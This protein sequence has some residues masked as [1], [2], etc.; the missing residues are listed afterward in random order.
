[1]TEFELDQTTNHERG[2][3]ITFAPNRIDVLILIALVVCLTALVTSIV[4][5]ANELQQRDARLDQPFLYGLIALA[6]AVGSV[7]TFRRLSVRFSIAI[8]MVLL[9]GLSIHHFGAGFV[10]STFPISQPFFLPD[11]PSDFPWFESV[12]LFLAAVLGSICAGWL[13]LAILNITWQRLGFV[14]KLWAWLVA[15]RL[16]FMIGA[17]GLLFVLQTIQ[18]IWFKEGFGQSLTPN[19]SFRAAT[20]F[21]LD[22]LLGIGVTALILAACLFATTKIALSKWDYVLRFVLM[23]LIGGLV[24][25]PAFVNSQAPYNSDTQQLHL[26]AS[27]LTVAVVYFFGLL[28]IVNPEPADAE[29]RA[30]ESRIPS[31][32]SLMLAIPLCGAIA[33]GLYVYDPIWLVNPAGSRRA[34]NVGSLEMASLSR[35]LSRES[36][37]RIG[38]MPA[39]SSASWNVA[40]HDK[41]DKDIFGHPFDFSLSQ[42]IIV[43]NIQPFVD[44]SLLIDPTPVNSKRPPI[45]LSLISGKVTSKQLGELTQAT[46][47]IAF[48]PD[49]ELPTECAP[50][51]VLNKQISFFSDTPHS[52]A[53]FLDSHVTQRGPNLFVQSPLSLEDWEAVIRASQHRRVH[54]YAVP[55]RSV[56]SGGPERLSLSNITLYAWSDVNASEE[57]MVEVAL[58]TDINLASAQLSDQR[59]WELAFVVR[60]QLPRPDLS[61]MQTLTGEDFLKGAADRYWIKESSPEGRP[62]EIWF[63]ESSFVGK[64]KTALG[65]LKTLRID[66]RGITGLFAQNAV[67]CNSRELAGLVE[68]EELHLPSG[69]QLDDLEFLKS[70]PNIRLLQIQSQDRTQQTGVGFDQCEK[71][72]TL[73]MFAGPD[74]QS[75]SELATLPNLKSITIVDDENAFLTEK[76]RSGLREKLPDATV[77]FVNSE[78]YQPIR[79]EAFQKQIEQ[80]R[81]RLKQECGL[82]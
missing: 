76:E 75:I 82:E 4:T 11:Q 33:F 45:S 6:F 44:T 42:H 47:W 56:W 26:F 28:V 30:S 10:T 68:L 3:W 31:I 65:D 59:L 57:T 55:P 79:S 19:G 67:L 7:L 16:K 36:N 51:V 64:H 15:N 8:L 71:L 46:N 23:G 50:G 27:F 13:S 21:G 35:K 25:L 2:K 58:E 29:T 74:K 54:I 52:I 62:L 14:N 60:S 43:R 17:A 12:P 81:Q 40:F 49:V 39:G 5:A 53:A 48:G 77:T 22:D 24:V 38:L 66:V 18:N 1:M 80:T 72:E 20:S 41:D 37:G 69:V 78:D 34:T 70:S 61:A 63:P 73:V 9:A 32:W